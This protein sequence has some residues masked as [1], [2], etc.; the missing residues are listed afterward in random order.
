MKQGMLLL[1]ILLALSL[2]LGGPAG[3]EEG[4]FLWDGN[5]WVQASLD[6]KIGYIWGVGNLADLEVTSG[7]AKA[8][9][10]AQALVREMKQKT[11]S[12]IVQEVDKY[13]QDNPAEIK[14]SVIEVILHRYR[15][16]MGK[17]VKGE[18]KKP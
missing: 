18:G 1:T 16:E 5:R 9:A 11:V 7:K 15:K 17:G 10:I 3:A 6:G 4:G 13:Y 14:T 2:S 8:G 12:Q